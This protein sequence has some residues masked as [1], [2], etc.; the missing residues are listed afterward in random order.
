[1]GKDIF[2]SQKMPNPDYLITLVRRL[3]FKFELMRPGV[4]NIHDLLWGLE[5][6]MNEKNIMVV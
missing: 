3:Y 2:L 6:N 1:M 5:S 4:E